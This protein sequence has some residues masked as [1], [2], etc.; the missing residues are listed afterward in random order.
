MAGNTSV[1]GQLQSVGCVRS[2]QTEGENLNEIWAV[3][4]VRVLLKIKSKF[5]DK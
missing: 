1:L 5:F 2:C 3:H 4:L